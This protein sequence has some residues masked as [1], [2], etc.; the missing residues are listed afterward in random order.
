MTRTDLDTS[1]IQ[2]AKRRRAQPQQQDGLRSKLEAARTALALVTE[3]PDITELIDH[4]TA[5]QAAAKARHISA[6]GI[7]SWTMF[8]VDAERKAWAHIKAMDGQLAKHRRPKASELRT[9]SDLDESL[10]RQRVHEWGT[11]AN[12]T[13][14]QLNEL[15]RVANEEDRLITRSELLTLGKAVSSS[16]KGERPRSAET[17]EII[18]QAREIAAGITE[19]KIEISADAKVNRTE[20]GAWVESWIWVEDELT[21]SDIDQP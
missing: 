1:E 7:N 9:L 10:T 6:E 14:N 18:E 4:A 15:E 3:L 5:I 2:Q 21:H 16:S 13:D 11:L 8:I 12:L 17:V 20:R 19:A